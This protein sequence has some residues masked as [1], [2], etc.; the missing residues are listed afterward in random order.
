MET[1]AMDLRKGLDGLLKMYKKVSVL[2]MQ[3]RFQR[4]QKDRFEMED[5]KG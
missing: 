1:V 4:V 2:T 3:K 5:V